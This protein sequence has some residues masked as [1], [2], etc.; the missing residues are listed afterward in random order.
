MRPDANGALFAVLFG[1]S[2]SFYPSALQDGRFLVEFYVA[3]PNDVRFNATNQRFWLQYCNHTAPTFGTMDIHLITPLDTSEK[4]ALHQHLVLV[5]CWVNLTHSD[6]FIYGPFDFATVC[7]RKTRDCVDQ[8]AWNSLSSTSS[9]IVNKVPCFD[10]LT[11][12][13]HLDHSVHSIFTVMAVVSHH[14]ALPPS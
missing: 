9:M 14:E 2:I 11:Y 6:T 3:H 4:C 8:D 13:I 7:G 10:L 1:D 5:H 12:S